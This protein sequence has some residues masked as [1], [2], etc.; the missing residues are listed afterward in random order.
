MLSAAMPL[1]IALHATD[2]VVTGAGWGLLAI[3]FSSLIPYAIIRVGV[4]RGHLTDHHIGV[5]E[6][7]RVPLLLGLVSV[8]VG[9][10]L[11]VL[12]DGPRQLT[13][14]VAAMLVGLLG[15]AVVNQVW[16]LSAHA[17]VA[18]GSATVLAMVFGPVLLLA[19]LPVALVGWSRVRLGDHTAGQVVAGAA[20]GAVLTAA[21]FGLIR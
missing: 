18:A 20:L 17:A 21:T 7:R 16:K 6:Q 1:V 11:L 8:L 15:V 2:R 13:A 3:T 10:A 9:L 12:L 14:L 4:H 19:G 5:R